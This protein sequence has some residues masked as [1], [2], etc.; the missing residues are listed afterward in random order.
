MGDYKA[1]DIVA[2]QLAGEIACE[3]CLTED[4]WKNMSENEII[5]RDQLEE[6]QVVFCDR[7]KKRL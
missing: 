4:E 3:D 7:C 6:E 2:L 5:T 1:E